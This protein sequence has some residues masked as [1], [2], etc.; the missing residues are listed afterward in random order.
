M[1]GRDRQYQ[2]RNYLAER[3]QLLARTYTLFRELQHR[4]KNNLQVI[5]SLVRLSAKRAPADLAEYFEE[6]RRQIWAIGQAHHK[7]YAGGDLD[8]IELSSYIADI[9]DQS[10]IGFGSLNDRVRVTMQLEPISVD[11]DAAIPIGLIVT[12]LLTNAFKYAF[13][14]GRRGEVRIG[15]VSRS[16]YGE[17]TIMDDGVG[18]PTERDGSGFRIVQALV[19]QIEGDLELLTRT[20]TRWI[21]RFP[22][23]MA[24]RLSA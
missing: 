20:G 13:P 6:V 22:L 17:L 3:E 12:E 19:T 23:G 18:L 9:V 1:R 7:L 8:H 4:V 16:G 11:V 14:G 24:K 5:Q 10:V 21:L 15:L 2:L